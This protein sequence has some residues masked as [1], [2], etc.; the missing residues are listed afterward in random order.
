MWTF[1]YWN[2]VLCHSVTMVC[3]RYCLLAVVILMLICM[4]DTLAQWRVSQR[5]PR[6]NYNLTIQEA[7]SIAAL[8]NIHTFQQI[9][10]PILVPRIVS[11]PQHRQ[12]GEYLFK[13]MQDAGFHVEWDEFVDNTPYGSNQFRNIIA[14]FD[15]HAPRRLVLACH[16]DSKILKGSVFIGAVDSAVPCAM[17]V[18]FAN[19]LGPL[20]RSHSNSPIT[21]QLV[22]LDGEEAFVEWT[23]TDSTYGARHLA[24]LWSRQWYPTSSRTQPLE[25]SRELDRIDAFVLLDLLGASNPRIAHTIGHGTKPLFVGLENIEKNLRSA[26]KL[27]PIPQIFSGHDS[28]HAVEDDHIP[29]MESGV[30]IMHLIPVPFPT[31]WHTP[32]DNEK[33]LD[34][35]TIY[36]LLSILRVF[37]AEYLGL[38]PTTF[39]E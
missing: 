16:Y 19:T 35:R 5:P 17:L 33:A 13:K 6:M 3:S 9:L 4:G 27:R 11:T 8:T 26:G 20:L 25:L 14:T 30:P 31:V 29:F 2:R 22:F 39:T 23:R 38:K 10:K 37:V 24:N 28:W 21:L 12:V 1:R 34:N 18:D 36:N 7:A 15:P 32:S